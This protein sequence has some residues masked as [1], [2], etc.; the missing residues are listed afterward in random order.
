MVGLSFRL[1]TKS[2]GTSDIATKEMNVI[3]RSSGI[4]FSRR[5]IRKRDILFQWTCLRGLI[6]RRARGGESSIGLELHPLRFVKPPHRR[7]VVLERVFP[8]RIAL[9]AHGFDYREL[10]VE[11]LLNLPV[12]WRALGEIHLRRALIQQR[13]DFGLPRRRRGRLIRIPDI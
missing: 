1:E 12:V 9:L 5:R 10:L 4:I 6:V 13:V 8:R 2:P 7:L 3:P 11:D